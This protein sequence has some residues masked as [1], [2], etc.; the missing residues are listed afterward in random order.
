MNRT[1]KNLL[2]IAGIIAALMGAFWG[3]PSILQERY[4]AAAVSAIFLI[5]GLILLAVAFGD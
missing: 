5:S 3:I 2:G 4:T 1:S